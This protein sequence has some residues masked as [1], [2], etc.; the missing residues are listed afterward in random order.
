MVLRMIIRVII[1]GLFLVGLFL[2]VGSNP[3]FAQTVP[4]DLILLYTNN[5]WAE[6]DPCP[7]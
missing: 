5:I 2:T 7:V 3:L 4:K 6:I 1:R